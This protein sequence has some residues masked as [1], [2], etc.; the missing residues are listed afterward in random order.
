MEGSFEVTKRA[1]GGEPREIKCTSHPG[2]T[3]TLASTTWKTERDPIFVAQFAQH[4][5]SS[6]TRGQQAFGHPRRGR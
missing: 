2:C 1:P 4:L 5:R 3:W 6:A